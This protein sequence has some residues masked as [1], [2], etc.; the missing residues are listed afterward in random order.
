[1]GRRAAVARWGIA[2]IAF[3]VVVVAASRGLLPTRA[4]DCRTSGP[5]SEIEMALVFA[6]MLVTV[7]GL[8]VFA[9]PAS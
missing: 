2:D 3:A 6:G 5:R 1:V 9:A 4:W 7:A 8:L